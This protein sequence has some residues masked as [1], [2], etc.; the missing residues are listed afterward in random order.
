MVRNPL[1]SLDLC[2]REREGREAGRPPSG[3]QTCLLSSGVWLLPE[4]ML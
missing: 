4:L 2:A 3:T 1:P